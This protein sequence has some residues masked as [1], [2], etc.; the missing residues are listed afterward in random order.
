MNHTLY[1][2]LQI[3]ILEWWDF[4]RLDSQTTTQLQFNTIKM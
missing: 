4:K 2:K 1:S 3:Y